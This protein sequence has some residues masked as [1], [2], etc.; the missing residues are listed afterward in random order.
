M[1]N[2]T[3]PEE[4]IDFLMATPKAFSCVEASRVQPEERPI[5][6]DSLTRLLHRLEPSSD[7]LWEEVKGELCQEEGY[8]I[9][10][11]S[12]LDK[13]YANKMDLVG[14]HWSGKHKKVVKGI[15]LVSLLWTDGDRHIPCDYRIYQGGEKDCFTKNDLFIQMLDIAFQRGFTP[16]YVCFDSWYGSLAN[17][18]HIRGLGYQW[19]TRFRKNRQV[20]PDNTKNQAIDSIEIPDEGRVVHL[21][22]YGFVKVFRIATK[23]GGVGYWA[24]SD[25]EMTELGRLKPAEASW[26]IEEYHQ[27]IKQYCGIERCQARSERAQKNHI[28][29]AIRA[30]VRFEKHGWQSGITWFNA[31]HG[32]IRDAVRDYL[33]N[34]L[35]AFF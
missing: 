24:T 7:E 12:T 25:L 29:M 22:G 14:F 8:L 5:S 31:K 9:V 19:L 33:Q 16:K 1:S 10:D 2:R 11:D 18:K 6:H 23:K 35:F 17:L 20:N 15:N 30:F 21:K 13:P 3:S 4:Y 26:K 34:P 28:G 27:G 32:I